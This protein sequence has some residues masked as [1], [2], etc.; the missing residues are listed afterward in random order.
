MLE[1]VP[2]PFRMFWFYFIPNVS[3]TQPLRWIMSR[4]VGLRHPW[5]WPGILVT[6]GWGLVFT[7][8]CAFLLRRK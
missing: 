6:V 3:L 4:G 7:V 5:V 8:V 2:Y 1:V